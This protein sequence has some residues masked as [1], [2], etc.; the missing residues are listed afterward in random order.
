MHEERIGQHCTTPS[1]K[2]FDMILHTEDKCP[3][4]AIC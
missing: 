3:K 4:R 1:I 2:I